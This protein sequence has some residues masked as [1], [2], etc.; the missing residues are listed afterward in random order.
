MGRLDQYTPQ[1]DIAG[2]GDVAAPLCATAGGFARDEPDKGHERGRKR[3]LPQIAGVRHERNGANPVDAPQRLKGQQKGVER[4]G[5][6]GPLDGGIEWLNSRVEFLS[7]AQPFRPHRILRGR[8]RLQRP[9]PLAVAQ[10]P[11]QHSLRAMN[12][13]AQ[14]GLQPLDPRRHQA[15][16]SPAA[17]LWLGR[18]TDGGHRGPPPGLESTRRSLIAITNG[19]DVDHNRI[20]VRGSKLGRC[21]ASYYHKIERPRP[22][23]PVSTHFARPNRLYEKSPR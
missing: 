14:A 18:L 22:A 23:E 5:W 7:L 19:G 1:M 10:T 20:N 15:S 2:F 13:P 21:R 6:H 12:A 4:M 17:Y 11:G 8:V 3:K 16:P 9:N